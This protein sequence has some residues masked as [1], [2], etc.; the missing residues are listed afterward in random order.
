MIT[1]RPAM[2]K[3]FAFLPEIEMDAGYEL[4][5]YGLNIAAQMPAAPLQYYSDLSA[6]SSVFVACMDKVIVGFSVC[7][8]VDFEGHLKE[9]SVL[10]KHMQKG[11]GKR[12]IAAAVSWAIEQDYTILTLT[13]YRDINFNAPFYE[14]LGFVSFEP[15]AKW[16]DLMA[17]REEERAIG[18]DQQPRI[19]MKLSLK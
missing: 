18:L 13:T 4:S 5:Q 3:D 7:K 15:D 11:I 6:S 8:S 1:V 16:P 14:K 2:I 17:I 10:R 19:C 12:L 9:V